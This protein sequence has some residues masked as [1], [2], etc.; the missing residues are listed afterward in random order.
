MNASQVYCLCLTAINATVIISLG[1]FVWHGANH[2]LIV[3][4]AILATI[5][6]IPGKNFFTCPACGHIGPIK[7]FSIGKYMLDAIGR[8]MKA[9]QNEEKED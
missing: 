5:T 3:V 7:V 6:V 8:D 1:Y 9:V 2:W 4:M